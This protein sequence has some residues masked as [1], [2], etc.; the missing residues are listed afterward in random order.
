[1]CVMYHFVVNWSHLGLD[2]LWLIPNSGLKHS[3]LPL[4]KICQTLGEN[5]IKCLPALHALTG[6]NTT[7]NIATKLAAL[8]AIRNPKNLPLLANFNSPQLT[9]HEIKLAET[10]DEL[11]ID[12]FDNNAL[13]LDFEKTACTS[14]N[15]RL[16]IKRS[17]YQMQ[18]WI[19]AP[20]RDASTLLNAEDHGFVTKNNFLIP[21]TNITKP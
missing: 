9:D 8:T 18:L 7:S 11:S 6:C 17:Y 12:T 5:L 14:T 10:F 16:H 19:Q 2:E 20:F 3:I 15:I 4:K 1:M 13:K 21:E